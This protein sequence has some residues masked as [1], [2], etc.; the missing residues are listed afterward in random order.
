M[1]TK[2]GQMK[3]SFGMIFSIILIIIFIVIA[4]YAIQKFLDL[5]QNIQI[6][7]FADSLKS[8]IDKMWGGSQGSQEFEYLV[9]S[10]TKS[11]CFIEDE[12]E[13]LVARDKE[14]YVLLRTNIEHI[15]IEE[16]LRNS[17]PFCPE[18]KN[19]K[20]SIILKKEYGQI[21]VNVIQN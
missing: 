8:D 6:N 17:D 15:N 1:K 4:F 19:N 11:I 18:I 2:R 3:M 5:Q 13:N 9:P 12:Y 16:M 14:G 21:L 20:I 7:Q 10:K